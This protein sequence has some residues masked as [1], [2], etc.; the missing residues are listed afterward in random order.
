MVAAALEYHRRESLPAGGTTSAGSLRPVEDW[1][2]DGEVI[3]LHPDQV[4]VVEDWAMPE[5]HV[6]PHP[7]SDG[8]GDLVVQAVGRPRAGRHLRRT[9][10]VAPQAAGRH[11]SGLVQRLARHA[12][13]RRATGSG[14]RSPSRC[15]PASRCPSPSTS[16]SRRRSAPAAAADG[17]PMALSIL[18]IAST[19]VGP[20]GE[21]A[22][23]PALDLLQRRPPRLA[24][25]GALPRVGGAGRRCH[26]RRPQ[27]PRPFVPGGAGPARHRQEH[28]RRQGHRPAHRRRVE[29]R[30]RRPEP[31]ARSRGCW[32]RWSTRASTPTSSSRRSD[33]GGDHLG[34]V[35]S[36]DELLARATGGPELGGCLIGGTTWDFVNENRVP[37]GCARPARDRRGRPVLAGRHHRRLP[38]RAAAPAA[39][40]PAAAVRRSARPATPNRSTRPRSTG[41]AGGHDT[42]PP[43]LG[44]FLDP[45]YRMRPELA[46]GGLAP[47]LRRPARSRPVHRRAHARRHRAR[48]PHR[49]R[50]APG[51]PGRRPTRRP[52]QSCG[53]VDDAAR[54]HLDRS[55]RPERPDPVRSTHADVVVVAPVQRPGQPHPRACSTAAGLHGVAVGTVDKF[56]GQEAA[57][58]IV[59]MASSSA[60]SSS[61]GAGFL[62]SPPPA[63]RGPLPGAAHRLPGP[64][65]AA[66]RP[67]ARHA[68]TA[69]RSSAPSWACRRPGAGSACWRAGA[70]RRTTWPRSRSSATRAGHGRSTASS[71]ASATSTRCCSPPV[72]AR[73]RSPSGTCS[74]TWRWC[75]AR[76]SRTSRAGPATWSAT[77]TAPLPPASGPRPHPSGRRAG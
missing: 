39:R 23:H 58:V 36:D 15:P 33:G 7:G 67:R 16:G 35:A 47:R 61:R 6:P 63:Q 50:R 25:G 56:Q 22:A 10:G 48:P 17:K 4:A 21:L 31:Q 74:A 34:T 60:A 3:V 29:D 71:S 26:R 51:Q 77:R 41:C 12:W 45:T 32:T 59:S 19:Q 75:R 43:E 46:A 52:T 20:G 53:L 70:S 68:R 14:S 42:L 30:R 13:S 65:A 69:S 5:P 62:L 27:G 54:P 1:E 76:C 72:R 66:H 64:H 28:H 49:A 37:A 18:E 24:S 57:V 8:R 73:T 55:A 2:H 9:A 11:R 44:Y 38:G 40:R